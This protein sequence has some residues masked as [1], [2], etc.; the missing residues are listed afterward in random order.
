MYL[1]N[2][3]LVNTLFKTVS[4][5]FLHFLSTGQPKKP[6]LCHTVTLTYYCVL[7]SICNRFIKINIFISPFI[8]MFLC[9]IV[10]V[11]VLTCILCK[12]CYLLQMSH[13]DTGTIPAL[14]YYTILCT[15]LLLYLPQYVSTCL[16]SSYMQ[17][18]YINSLSI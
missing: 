13:G 4:L 10:L 7:G 15:I 3:I 16:R 1:N 14:L 2:V 5:K 11:Q 17:F 8:L 18:L 12:K 6:F 9:Y